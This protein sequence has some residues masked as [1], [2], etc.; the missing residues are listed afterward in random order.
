MRDLET[1][2]DLPKPQTLGLKPSFGF[3]D[4][5]G[6]ATP[7]HILAAKRGN[8]IPVFAQQS[9][10]EM[11]RTGRTPK[12]VM[13][14]AQKSLKKAGWTQSWGA[15]ADHLKTQQDVI[16]LALAGFTFFT[17][18]PSDYVTNQADWLTGMDLQDAV[19]A[20]INAG[21]FESIDQIEQLYFNQTV[22]LSDQLAISCDEREELFRA[23]VKYG[24]AV[25]YAAQMTNWI[26]S[27]VEDFELEIS[28]DETDTP[29]SVWEHLFIA[30]ELKRRGVEVVSLA[31]RFVGEVE[32]GIDYKGDL[33]HFEET[34]HQHVAVAQHCGPYKI[35]VH[36]GSDK[37]SIYPIL[38]RVCRE[39]LHVKT[40]GTSYLEAL[41]VLARQHPDAFLEILKYSISRFETDRATYHISAQVEN[42]ADPIFL[43]VEKREEKYLD[44]DDGRQVL[45]VAFGS[46]LTKGRMPNDQL[47]NEV[48]METLEQHADLYEQFLEAHLGR[49]IEL[50]SA[51]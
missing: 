47:F 2:N 13:M 14:A 11:E 39:L 35:S 29:T 9:V 7:G 5:L 48:I 17:I 38:G 24:K 50:L 36:S 6:L 18:D 27:Q 25:D 44:Q 21:A 42:L 19:E 46:V 10:R 12:D 26:K 41:R 45:H 32:K 51:G 43:N 23:V 4:R 33:Q 1:M 37:F 22:E 31:P 20:V 28:V 30:L 40:A 16:D 3:G 49:H 34:L 15:D 8:M